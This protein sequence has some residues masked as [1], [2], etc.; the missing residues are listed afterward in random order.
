MRIQKI[1]AWYGP[2]G[3]QIRIAKPGSP[4]LHGKW[5]GRHLSMSLYEDFVRINNKV[6]FMPVPS[7]T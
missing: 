4:S 7:V 1:L 2:S 5:R 3:Y 6:Q